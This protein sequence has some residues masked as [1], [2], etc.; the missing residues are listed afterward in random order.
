MKA[1]KVE[2][3]NEIDNVTISIPLPSDITIKNKKNP[4]CYDCTIC[5]L[6]CIKYITYFYL[7]SVVG[8]IGAKFIYWANETN[9][10]K[11][12]DGWD[13]EDI[14]SQIFFQAFVGALILIILYGACCAPN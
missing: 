3:A 2:P 10:W 13:W 5:L 8:K 12:P 11:Y 4:L 7:L 6:Y 1:V 14:N 9:N